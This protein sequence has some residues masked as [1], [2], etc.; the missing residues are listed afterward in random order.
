MY[1]S[2]IEP[3]LDRH[4][5]PVAAPDE[6][7][8]R[9]RHPVERRPIAYW[10]LAFAMLVVVAT[11]WALH[12]RSTSMESERAGEIS[13]WINARCGLSVPLLPSEE[14]RL[15]GARQVGAG[16]AEIRYRLHEHESTL[17]VSK[18]DQGGHHGQAYMIVS[19]DLQNACLLCHA[20]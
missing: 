15:L 9:V 3:V 19:A 2:W 17:L 13:R 12:P 18:I 4:M 6:L 8:D 5:A 16:A 10:K 11:G 1:K 20:D 7:W 14:V